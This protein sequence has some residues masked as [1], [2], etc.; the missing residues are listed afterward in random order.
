MAV[1][2]FF[3]LQHGVLKHCGAQEWN[4]EYFRAAFAFTLFAGYFLVLNINSLL[5]EYAT[6]RCRLGVEVTERKT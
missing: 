2:K 6:Y 5:K 3:H 4:E 1:T